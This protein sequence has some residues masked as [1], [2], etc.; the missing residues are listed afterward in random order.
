M[1]ENLIDKLATLI[2]ND[3]SVPETANIDEC[4][5]DFINEENVSRKVI[6]EIYDQ[7]KSITNS[8]L[9]TETIECLYE[10]ARDDLCSILY[11]HKDLNLEST[12][13]LN[14]S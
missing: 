10:W 12:S 5:L 4:I 8:K 6:I 14:M 3:A 11:S 2:E 9:N 13:L 1:H 7:E